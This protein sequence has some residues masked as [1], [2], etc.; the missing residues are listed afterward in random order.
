MA[1]RSGDDRGLRGRRAECEALDGLV[2]SLRAGASGTLVLHGETGIG[3]S[4]LLGYLIAHAAGCRIAR[5]AGVESETELA[6]AGLHQLCLPFLDRLERLPLP[7]Q[8]ALSTAFGCRR[9]DAPDRF[10]VGLA[11]LNLLSD[12]AAEQ[13][14]VCVVDDA[15]W[16]DRISAQTLAFVAR[17]LV[18][19][20]VGVVFALRDSGD[21][22]DLT[23]LPT[24]AVR[25]LTES[26]AQGL[27]ESAISGP[28]DHGVRDRIVAETRGNPA[29]LLE[30]PRTSSPAELAFGFGFPG[31]LRPASRLEQ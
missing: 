8:D 2:D 22:P 3:K 1:M 12:A 18:A 19:E 25:G 5:A 28:L 31:E 24:L 9:G 27:L 11:V 21:G 4:A 23:G 6:F 29:E 10:L 30:L 20:S 7:Q 26:D 15:Q 14:L 17:R 13:P 16:L